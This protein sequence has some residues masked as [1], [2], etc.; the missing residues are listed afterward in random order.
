MVIFLLIDLCPKVGT[1]DRGDFEHPRGDFERQPKS[2]A[3]LSITGGHNGDANKP[4][5]KN[6]P[7]F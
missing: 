2:Y 3:L 4:S 1:F 5:C 6:Q 7:L